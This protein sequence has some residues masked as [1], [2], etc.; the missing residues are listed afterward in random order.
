M[1]IPGIIPCHE[2]KGKRPAG[3][4]KT[5]HFL[6]DAVVF[7]YNEYSESR[8]VMP[9]THSVEERGTQVAIRVR[10]TKGLSLYFGGHGNA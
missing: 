9:G 5:E 1:G 3:V 6:G 4:E 10:A 8:V 2:H 7:V